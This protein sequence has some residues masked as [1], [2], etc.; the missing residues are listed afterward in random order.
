VIDARQ[1]RVGFLVAGCFFMEIMDGTIVSTAAPRLSEALRVPVSSIG[2]LIT[3]YFVTVAA[4]CLLALM[5]Q[6]P[7][8]RRS[9]SDPRLRCRV[10]VS[11]RR[12]RP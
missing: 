9:R 1:R 8:W 11:A 3:A 5:P 12:A 2:L 6:P 7:R 10:P 4:G